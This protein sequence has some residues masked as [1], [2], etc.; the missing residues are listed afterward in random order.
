MVTS[1]AG[2]RAARGGL[3]ALAAI[4]LLAAGLRTAVAAVSPVAERIGDDIPLDH[5]LLGVIGAAPPLV[6]AL[7]GLLAPLLS[8]RLGLD[9]AAL[10][11]VVAGIIGHLLRAVA[12][13]AITLTL[14]TAIALLGA[15][16]G[17]VLL[18]PLVKRYFPHRL[19]SVTAAYLTIMSIG[20]AL[21]PVIAVPLAD[22]AGW[23]F[24]LGVWAAT[25]V[26]ALVPW[27]GL[28]VRRPGGAEPLDAAA[29]EAEEEPQPGLSRALLRSPIAWS[30][31]LLF[32]ASA[33]GAYAAFGWLPLLLTDTAGVSDA[34]AGALLGVFAIGG[35]PAG[36]LVPV[37]ATR[38]RAVFWLVIA[39]I[40]LFAGGYAGLLVAPAAAPL[41]WATFYGLGPLVFP[42]ALTLINTRTRTHAGSVALSGFVQGVGYVIGAVGPLLVGA[43]HDATGGWTAPLI[44]MLASVLLAVPAA[45][46]LRRGGTVEDEL[47]AR[48]PARG[49]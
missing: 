38:P 26:A 5:I 1:A 37:L 46:V 49:A 42:L 16:V 23:R 48:V 6:F 25:S 47:A 10:A 32:G 13:E 28:L 4:V 45:V 11:T 27:I 39:G 12:P 8:R 2:P 43:L 17:N 7:S 24:S 15:G 18:P 30:L 21:P 29:R 9:G 3:L 35:L 19:G 34:T 41:L 40:A 31:A 36:L 20:A 44:A 33:F 14:G 22:A